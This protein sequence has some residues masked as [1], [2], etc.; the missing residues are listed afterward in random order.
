MALCAATFGETQIADHSEGVRLEL[1]VRLQKKKKKSP[2]SEIL[3]RIVVDA[4]GMF[5]SQT[6]AI[7]YQGSEPTVVDGAT[8]VCTRLQGFW[9]DTS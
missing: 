2:E 4:R 7:S 1:P 6:S 9:S 3:A 5:A 8:Q